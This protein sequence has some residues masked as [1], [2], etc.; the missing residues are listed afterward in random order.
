[1]VMGF[2]C[3]CLRVFYMFS[4]VSIF[5][6]GCS[7]PF[8]LIV[9]FSYSVLWLY[10]ICDPPWTLCVDR[11]TEGK[12]P[13][14]SIE[15]KEKLPYVFKR[16]PVIMCALARKLSASLLMLSMSITAHAVEATTEQAEQCYGVIRLRECILG[17]VW[18]CLGPRMCVLTGRCLKS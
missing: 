18:A 5:F 12:K 8:V 13:F 6:I 1:M 3:F 15:I 16:R 7:S 17:I 2:L 9:A 11:E 14:L 10:M 4:R